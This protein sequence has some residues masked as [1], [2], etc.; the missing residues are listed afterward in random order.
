MP[1]EV[2]HLRALALAVSVRLCT[3]FLLKYNH[4]EKVYGVKEPPPPVVDERSAHMLQ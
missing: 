4:S 1:S 2:R 3:S